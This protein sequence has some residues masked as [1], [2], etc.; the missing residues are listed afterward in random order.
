MFPPTVMRIRLNRP[1][2]R[3]VRLIVPLALVYVVA[4]PFLLLLLSIAAVVAGVRRGPRA[5]AIAVRGAGLV[6]LT[7]C[8]LRGLRL[9]LASADS[10]LFL[11]FW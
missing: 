11:A 2:R 6:L 8:R 9:D 10:E 5:A 3:A 1:G 7:F 4:L